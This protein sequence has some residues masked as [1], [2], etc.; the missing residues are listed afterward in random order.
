[1]TNI[2]RV[3]N[4]LE[5]LKENIFLRYYNRNIGNVFQYIDM[6]IG[7][8]RLQFNLGSGNNVSVFYNFEIYAE[9]LL[10]IQELSYEQ[11]FN[12]P[13]NAFT[14]ITLT[15]NDEVD[16]FCNFMKR[17]EVKFLSVAIFSGL[18][19][20]HIGFS[21]L[22]NFTFEYI[23][24][25]L[26]IEKIIFEIDDTNIQLS[27]LLMKCDNSYLIKYYDQFFKPNTNFIR[28]IV[29]NVIYAKNDKIHKVDYKFY[30]ILSE[31][32]NS[33]RLTLA[34]MNLI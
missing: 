6:G 31:F 4:I 11:I 2:V 15:T 33:I 20:K 26:N 13:I 22:N 1:M 5:E 28:N 23:P 8:L 10:N 14:P 30:Q 18:I 7:K 29:Y 12:V 3:E 16:M 27:T 21:D 9:T 25:F 19:R 17:I 34:E 24:T 32:A